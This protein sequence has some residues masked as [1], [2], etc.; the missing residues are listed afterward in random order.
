MSNKSKKSK[1]RKSLISGL[2][3]IA[4]AV[5][6]SGAAFAGVITG[7]IANIILPVLVAGTVVYN[8]ILLARE[9]N[10]SVK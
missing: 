1:V 7:E 5:A 6:V 10:D 4:A 3:L 2:I 9:K 8:V